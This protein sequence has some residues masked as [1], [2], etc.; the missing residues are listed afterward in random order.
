M[1]LTHTLP[2]D[3]SPE[4]I[5]FIERSIEIGRYRTPS[6]AIQ[7][8]MRALLEHDA[9]IETWLHETVVASFL[10]YQA[11]PDTGVPADTVLSR[12]HQRAFARP[13]DQSST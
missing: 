13:T 11:D 3:L 1:T 2:I 9:S 5:A 10:E 8:G 12:I 6:E 4:T 7:D